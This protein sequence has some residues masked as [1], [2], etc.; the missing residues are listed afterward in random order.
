M[1]R[2]ATLPWIVSTLGVLA[3]IVWV[4][5]ELDP[6]RETP[7]RGSAPPCS[8][9]HGPDPTVAVAAL[10]AET[11]FSRHLPPGRMHPF[12]IR[13]P[14]DHYLHLVADQRGIDVALAFLVPDGECLLE[15]DTPTGTDGPEPL[16]V[17]APAA[18]DYRVE[19]RAVAGSPEGRYRLRV[20]ELRPATAED[21]LWSGSAR[22]FAEGEHLRARGGREGLREAVRAYRRALELMRRAGGDPAGE[23]TALR[24][25]GQSWSTLGE[26][27]S[28][29]RAYEEA[30]ELYRHLGDATAEA[31]L[32]NEAGST[33]RQ[34]GEPKRAEDY[35]RRALALAE[36]TGNRLSEVTATNNLGVLY[37]S[38]GE[39]QEALEH[40]DRALEG[41]RELGDRHRE[42]D[43]LHNLGSSYC[44]LGRFRD[45]LDLLGQAL[46]L[47]RR[48]GDRYR[49]AATLSAIGWAHY[50]ADDPTAAL[51]AFDESLRWRRQV[52][53]Q[54]G[55]AATLDR[56]AA[57]CWKLG[58]REEATS[59]LRRALE[60]FRRIGD[61]LNQAH[62]EANLGWVYASW[63]QPEEALEHLAPAQRFFRDVGDPNGEAYARVGSARAE[64]LRGDLGR[65]QSHLEAA[66]ELV[67]SV[68]SSVVSPSFRSSYLASRQDYY[69]LLIELL[70]ERH[71]REPGRGFDVRALE[72]SQRSRARGLLESL[73]EARV[74]LLAEA[75]PELKTSY[76]SLERE[77]RG[78]ERRRLALLNRGADAAEAAAAGRR[79]RRLLREYARLQGRLRKESLRYRTFSSPPALELP[80]L[81]SLLAPGTLLLWYALGSERSFLWAVGPRSFTSHELPGRAEIETAVRDLHELMQRSHLRGTR[82]QAALTAAAVSAM[83]LAP[84]ADRLEVERLVIAADGA[85]HYL[86]FAA[87]PLPEREERAPA[88]GAP[89]GGPLVLRHQIVHIPSASVLALLRR[90]RA[91]RSP[92]PRTVAVIADP[93]F[94]AEDSR[95]HPAGGAGEGAPSPLRRPGSSALEQAAAAAGVSGF[96]RLAHSR[97]EAASI[98]ARVPA[99]KS[100]SALDFEASRERVLAADLGRYR[101]LHFATHGLVNTEHPELSGLVLS[102]VDAAGRPRDGFLRLSDFYRLQL[103]A[104]LVVLSSC[105][106]AL[107]REVRGEGLVGLTG[108]FL[109]SGASR[110]LVSLWQVDDRATARL[111]DSFYHHLLERGLPPAAAL[112]QAQLSLLAD[113]RWSS[114]YYW[115]GFV[116]QGD[117][118][119]SSG[120]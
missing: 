44:R 72:V 90:E 19:V 76:R 42:A 109:S 63:G 101:I 67:E 35:Y 71:E 75:A 21:R 54:R 18:G 52:G 10:D 34:L 25:L 2:R 7:G 15:V 27:R 103:S 83:V 66:L 59:A 9:W 1:A 6:G 80:E 77:I 28:A 56:R 20:A 89:R 48:V 4:A 40:F 11:A 120:L 23:A 82:R 88:D 57:A 50:L 112:Q 26:V 14:A 96:E 74:D 45:A 117:W 119:P 106:T 78:L 86:P 118:K 100:F 39:V 79:L 99:G 69:E 84:V 85:L 36:A 43:T 58:R 24:R 97:R 113:E 65:A 98:L 92:G 114:P 47:W 16:R 70:M 53:D 13:L 41:W 107:G 115:A 32:L 17:V 81:R 91:G 104:D 37:D 3:A 55:E 110:V 22:A 94:S 73:T 87:L 105:R 111:M 60:I 33:F 108:G 38:L 12:R 49:Q 31:R 46:V 51:A 30:L 5:V 93:V 8:P 116:L 61:R 64:R 68:R 102:L 95:V 62:V 29:N